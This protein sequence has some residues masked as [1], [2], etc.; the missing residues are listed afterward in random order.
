MKDISIVG[1]DYVLR[2]KNESPL[3]EMEKEYEKIEKI[4]NR[5]IN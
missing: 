3:E 2:K 4:L 5:N 1:D